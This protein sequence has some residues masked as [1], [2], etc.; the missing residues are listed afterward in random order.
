MPST[1]FQGA[2]WL[3][4]HGVLRVCSS[5]MGAETMDLRRTTEVIFPLAMRLE[6]ASS[7]L[8]RILAGEVV[9]DWCMM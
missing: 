9:I 3:C 4:I 6:A 5:A 1:P 8:C 2:H 7:H